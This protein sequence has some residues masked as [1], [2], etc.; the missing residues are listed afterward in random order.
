MRGISR[1][2]FL[3]KR[4]ETKGWLPGRTLPL[5]VPA[6]ASGPPHPLALRGLRPRVQGKVRSRAAQWAHSRAPPG[7]WVSSPGTRALGAHKPA[8]RGQLAVGDR[9]RDTWNPRDQVQKGSVWSAQQSSGS[10]QSGPL[11][12][13]TALCACGVG[14]HEARWRATLGRRGPDSPRPHAGLGDVCASERSNWGG[15]TLK[16]DARICHVS[17][18][19]SLF[20]RK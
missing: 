19:T 3:S 11:G 18:R 2:G 17:E 5:G 16:V 9:L 4:R 10:P 1:S 8:L 12:L 14:P 13:N 20:T 15:R 7:S 6:W